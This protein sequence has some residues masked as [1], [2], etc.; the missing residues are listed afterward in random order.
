MQEQIYALM[1]TISALL[2]T[3][4]HSLCPLLQ[5]VGVCMR[6]CLSLSVC[7]SMSH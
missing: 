1:Q 2:L 6:V 5:S 7:L 3:I 4:P